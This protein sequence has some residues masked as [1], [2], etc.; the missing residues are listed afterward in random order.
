MRPFIRPSIFIADILLTILSGW[1]AFYLRFNFLIPEP[2][3]P[4]MT[5]IIAWMTASQLLF[6]LLWRT[7]KSAIV[8]FSVEDIQKILFAI[9]SSIFFLSIANLFSVQFF[10]PEKLRIVPNTILVI[11]HLGSL[12]LMICLRIFI[13]NLYHTLYPNESL[14]VVS[15]ENLWL[16]SEEMLLGRDAIQLESETVSAQLA[17]KVV[18]VT[19]AA[20]SIGR[21][22]S[23]QL[24]RFPVKQLLLLDQAESPLYDLEMEL[25]QSLPNINIEVIIADIRN[26]TRLESIF[27]TYHPQ[28]VYHA[29]AYKHVPMMEKYPLEAIQTNVF[30]TIHIADL[31]AKYSA[32]KCIIISTDK[33]VNPTSIMGEMYVQA[34]DHHWVKEGKNKP[35]FVTTRFGNV[36]G[37]DG[38][39][40]LLFQKQIAS[41]GPITVTHPNVTRFFMTIPEASQLVLEAGAMG[42][43]GEIYVFDMGTPVK[44]KDLAQQMIA[45]FYKKTGKKIDIEWIGLRQGEKLYEEVLHQLEETLPTH[46][47]KILIGKVKEYEYTL[48][49]KEISLLKADFEQQNIEAVVKRM[50]AIIPEFKS[51]NSTFER[52]DSEANAEQEQC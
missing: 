6:F 11:G 10:H 8:R 5:P 31:A 42:Q 22:L 37:S 52:L 2:W 47:P 16:H 12:F 48:I 40:F 18:L 33:A 39:V 19:G 49:F 50:K 15:S 45:F 32:E 26:K 41:G 36:L 46:H 13:R 7:D 4:Q 43:G 9:I 17:G 28:I 23:R 21:E 20:G 25:Q 24:A 3:A 51:Q 29:A 38:S 14:L 44:I 35:R 30:G 27:A 1:I 34:F